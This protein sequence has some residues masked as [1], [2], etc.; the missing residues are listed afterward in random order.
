MVLGGARDFHAIDW[1]RT[2]K[3][4]V[5]NRNVIFLTDL[6]ESEGY[7][8]IINKDDVLEKLFIIDRFLFLKQSKFGNI[9]RNVIKLIALPIQIFYLKR[10]VKKNKNSVY[11]AHP[12]YYMFLCWLAGV[13]F[14]GTPQG[15]EILVRPKRS[16]LYKYFAIQSL[17]AAKYV[18]VDS[19]NMKNEIFKLSG[20]EA[21]VIQYGVD[22]KK[23]LE[24]N[25]LNHQK[26]KIASIR[27][28]TDLYRI[29]EIVSARNKAKN[30]VSI[31]FIYP[32]VEEGYRNSTKKDFLA[33]DNDIGRL[34]K[35]EM[36]DLL[37]RAM[38]VFSIPRSDSSPRSVYEAIFL[39]CCVAV[40]YNLWIESLPA[41]MK[42]RLYIVDLD[43]N[44][45]FDKAIEYAQKVSKIKYEPSEEAL[46]IFDQE[47]S[48]KKA[49]ETLY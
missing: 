21:L 12:M 9:W 47:I 14:I 18:T 35:D 10:Y 44:E 26:N 42:E 31:E 24:I 40:T 38:L 15:D 33:E 20:V 19:V 32:F 4:L 49:I 22:T 3:K 27:A 5:V 25:H 46:E 45:W 16:K 6:I 48:M 43:D 36:Y 28:I 23:L 34:A 39:G 2:V 11:H 1:Y 37:S 8:R 29:K 41:C 30:K 13:E 7:D 17:K